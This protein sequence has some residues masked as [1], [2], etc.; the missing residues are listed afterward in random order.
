MEQVKSLAANLTGRSGRAA[1][2]R[3]SPDDVV[4]TLAVRSPCVCSELR[5][6]GTLKTNRSPSKQPL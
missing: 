2:E 6:L 3:K 1:L 4:I 5:R